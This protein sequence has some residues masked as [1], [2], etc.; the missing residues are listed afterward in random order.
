MMNTIHVAGMVLYVLGVEMMMRVNYIC[1]ADLALIPI[2]C[3]VVVTSVLVR[4]ALMWLALKIELWR[5][6]HENTSWHTAVP[7]EDEFDIP[8]WED[9]EGASHDAFIMNQRITEE[10][11]RWVKVSQLRWFPSPF[12]LALALIRI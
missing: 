10:T 8:D 2:V 9:V 6:K 3:F 12:A 7:E 11:F 5:I 4:K 1:L